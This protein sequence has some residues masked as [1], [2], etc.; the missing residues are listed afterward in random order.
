[1]ASF[2]ENLSFVE[3]IMIISSILVLIGMG[4]VAILC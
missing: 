1:M 3:R 2:M 4:L